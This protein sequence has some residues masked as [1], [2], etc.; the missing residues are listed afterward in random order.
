MIK[1]SNTTVAAVTSYASASVAARGKTKLAVDG[2]IAD[3]V[4][5]SDLEAPGKDADRTFYDSVV[6]SVQK[7]MSKN[8][9]ALLNADIKALSEENKAERRYQMQQRGSMVKDLRKALARRLA[10]TEQGARVAKT[11]T[12]RITARLLEIKELV[13]KAEEPTFEVTKVLAAINEL[14]KLVK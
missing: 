12:E 10:S 8:A 9:Q 1:L 5:P 7:G 11:L 4:K 6:E 2:F 13:V 14:A 3:G